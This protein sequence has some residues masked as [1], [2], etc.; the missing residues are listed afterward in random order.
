MLKDSK[1]VELTLS[2][3]FDAANMHTVDMEGLGTMKAYYEGDA[4]KLLD[5][6]QIAGTVTSTGR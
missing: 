4:V 6:V 3:M 1:V 5:I 2:E